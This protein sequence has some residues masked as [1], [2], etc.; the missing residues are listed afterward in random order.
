MTPKRYFHSTFTS[1]YFQ[2][3]EYAHTKGYSYEKNIERLFKKFITIPRRFFA[4]I[5]KT[6]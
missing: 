4:G 3:D 5:K 6:L 2:S 1:P